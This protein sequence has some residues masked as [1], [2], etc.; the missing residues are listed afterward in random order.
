MTFQKGHKPYNVKKTVTIE[1]VENTPAENIVNEVK[2]TAQPQRPPK[3]KPLFSRIR[4]KY[5]KEII[6]DG[7]KYHTRVFNDKDDR[8]QRAKEAGYITVLKSD[9]PGR[10]DRCGAASQMGEP[11]SQ[12]VG[13]GTTGVLMMIPDEFYQ[14][15]LAT[16]KR[17]LDEKEADMKKPSTPAGYGSV[18]I[19]VGN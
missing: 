3:R 2:E 10:D 12:P 7:V 6:K 8:I 1:P 4:L 11:V 17:W 13:R 14:E 9:L 19:E 18:K 15:D 5:P 16:R